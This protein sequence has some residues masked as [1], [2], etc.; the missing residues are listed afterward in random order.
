MRRVVTWCYQE[1]EFSCLLGV[2]NVLWCHL[3][4]TTE[5][6]H[7]SA[8]VSHFTIK[9]VFKTEQWSYKCSCACLLRISQHILGVKLLRGPR[10]CRVHVSKVALNYFPKWLHQFTPSGQQCCICLTESHAHHHFRLDSFMVAAP[11]S[12]EWYLIVI[13]ICISVITNDPGNLFLY[14]F[15]FYL[16]SVFTW[17]RLFLCCIRKPFWCWG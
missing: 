4:V 6:F 1:G 11:G 14:F 7:F 5:E 12:T 3:V 17:L 16:F 2:G 8:S 13:W 10:K 15:T 9:S